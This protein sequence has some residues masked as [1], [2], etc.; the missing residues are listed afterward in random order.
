MD[1]TEKFV[2]PSRP[3]REPI[4]LASIANGDVDEKERL[5][6]KAIETVFDSR[7]EL[8]YNCVC[9]IFDIAKNLL[10]TMVLNY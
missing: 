6:Y 8:S 2:V 3:K 1:T 7:D 10:K 5:A 4:F 9:E